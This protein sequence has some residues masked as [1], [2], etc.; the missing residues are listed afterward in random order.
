MILFKCHCISSRSN[1]GS[2]RSWI[3]N[4]SMILWP[5][6]ILLCV[7]Q[8]HNPMFSPIIFSKGV[9]TSRKVYQKTGAEISNLRGSFC[10]FLPK[11]TFFHALIFFP[12]PK[13]FIVDQVLTSGGSSVRIQA[14]KGIYEQPQ[15][16]C[17]CQLWHTVF[18]LSLDHADKLPK[19]ANLA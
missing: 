2:G 13:H 15:V 1:D 18:C 8:F 9:W 7:V 6:V 10:I 16:V 14:E 11:N 3:S 5:E 17:P 12:G 19:R 4:F